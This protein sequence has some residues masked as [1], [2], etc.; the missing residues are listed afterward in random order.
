MLFRPGPGLAVVEAPA[1]FHSVPAY[2]GLDARGVLPPL[3]RPGMLMDLDAHHAWERHAVRVFGSDRHTPESALEQLSANARAMAAW[4]PSHGSL[5]KRV[6]T[7]ARESRLPAIPMTVSPGEA[8]LLP[9][10]PSAQLHELVR[11]CVAEGLHPEHG[12]ADLGR[13]DVELV[14]P[15]WRALATPIKRYLAAKMFA[16]RIPWHGRGV[17]TTL[18]A[19][20]AARAVLRVEAGRQCAR[21]RRVLDRGLL[22]EAIRR[23]DLLLVHQASEKALAGRLAAVERDDRR[24]ARG[25]RRGHARRK[26]AS[27]R[28]NF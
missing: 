10:A 27:I 20:E 7:L 16:S 25:R 17:Q 2:E 14:E 9:G 26:T 5:R 28:T 15:G 4:Q 21:S 23:A 24:A 3:L 12:L 18:A 22:L 8:G 13:T 19:L 1:S 6:A 11:A